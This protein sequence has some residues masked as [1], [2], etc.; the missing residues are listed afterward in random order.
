[1]LNPSFTSARLNVLFPGLVPASS[2]VSILNPLSAEGAEM[3]LSLLSNLILALQ[4]NLRQSEAGVTAFELGKVFYKGNGPSAIDQQQEHVT[5]AGVLYG[6]WPVT[7]IAQQGRPVEFA[8]LKGVLEA[9]WQELH[10]ET[11]VRWTR[12]AETVFL[13]PG[14]AAVL[15]I[16]R[17]TLGVAGA[18]HYLASLC[19][20]RYPVPASPAFSCGCAGCCGR[21]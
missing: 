15:A 9:L 3:R 7:G 8:D 17:T 12:T 1:M 13:H 2:S 19:S 5:L 14:K 21:G 11:Q 6:N 4:H 20:S 18:L 16:D 10:Y